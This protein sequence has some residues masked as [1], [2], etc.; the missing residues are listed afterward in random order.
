MSFQII[1]KNF[2]IYR[3]PYSNYFS[4][5]KVYKWSAFKVTQLLKVR[6]KNL[7]DVKTFYIRNPSLYLRRYTGKFKKAHYKDLEK[8]FLEYTK[9]TT[10]LLKPNIYLSGG[11]AIKLFLGN[12]ASEITKDTHDFDFHFIAKGEKDI[13][14]Q[15]DAMVK[16]MYQ[17]LNSFSKYVN[18]KYGLKTRLFIKELKGV[19]VDNPAE[20][21]KYRKVYKV[22]K[23]FILTPTKKIEF[24]DS[25]LVK[26]YKTRFKRRYGMNIPIYRD[27][28]RDVAYT[29][30]STFLDERSYLRNPL[31]GSKYKKGIKDVARLRNLVKKNPSINRFIY[32]II[33]KKDLMESKKNAA[34]IRRQMNRNRLIHVQLNRRK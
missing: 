6:V 21:Y 11:M 28:W 18:K 7:A 2:I 13:G 1:P 29:L 10:R 27:L 23:F 3:K 31:I 25:S 22:Y 14:F 17:H 30:S 9:N 19:P 15:A 12:K 26:D 16:T 24:I 34:V 4:L 5:Q 33:V 20:G 32:N 8:L